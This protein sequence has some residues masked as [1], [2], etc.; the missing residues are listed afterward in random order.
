[1]TGGGRSPLFVFAMPRFHLFGDSRQT[2]EQ[3][4]F[5]KWFMLDPVAADKPAPDR[6]AAHYRPN[7]PAFHDLT[8]FIVVEAEDDT[9][10]SLE[11]RLVRAF[12]DHPRNGL[13]ARDIA[14]S[15]LRDA[16]DAPDAAALADLA[17]EIEFPREGT[18]P[19]ISARTIDVTLPER[20]S[21]GYQVFLGKRGRYE[22][23]LERDVLVL[24][25]YV[26]DAAPWLRM[27]LTAR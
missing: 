7:G 19:V 6:F 1:M 10:Q 24:E 11:L 25:N 16:V 18:V 8:E 15:M 17:N 14:K 23:R 20:P 26:R 5:F 2:A 13:F 12:I 9:L 3:S 27:V 21:P 4:G 22:Q